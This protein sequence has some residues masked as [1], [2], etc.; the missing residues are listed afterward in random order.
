MQNK[1]HILLMASATVAT[2]LIAVSQLTTAHEVP[3]NPTSPLE[4]SA[5]HPQPSP[6]HQAFPTPAALPH[7]ATV[8][9]P[10][11]SAPTH[12]AAVH[13]PVTASTLPKPPKP[14]VMGAKVAFPPAM[15]V[16]HVETDQEH[17]AAAAGL[18]RAEKT[19]TQ[20]RMK[21]I[22]AE[23]QRHI[24]QARLHE[25]AQSLH[26]NKLALKQELAHIE[27]QKQQLIEEQKRRK[28]ELLAL[29]EM[30]QQQSQAELE[31][32][33]QVQQKLQREAKQAA[34]DQQ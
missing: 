23:Q 13:F 32:L 10:Q 14:H 3:A 28:A 6:L 27:R 19:N 17:E 4:T 26:Q 29:V 2:A 15:P 22:E 11:L 8:P 12:D 18:H 21:R 7:V 25:Q 34:A 5:L 33:E 30:E 1:K 24:Q 16:A 9:K 20:A 31:R